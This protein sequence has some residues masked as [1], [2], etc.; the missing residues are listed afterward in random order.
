MERK[1]DTKERTNDSKKERERA[2]EKE[3]QTTS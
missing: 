2:S 1:R 3:R